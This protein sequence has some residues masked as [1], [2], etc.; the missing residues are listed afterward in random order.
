MKPEMKKSIK[1]AAIIAIVAVVAIIAL[2]AGMTLN[3]KGVTV[4]NIIHEDK[5]LV[6]KERLAQLD[7]RNTGTDI[8]VIQPY[9]THNAVFAIGTP[10]K[11]HNFNR[12]DATRILMQ[13][14]QDLDTVRVDTIYLAK[15]GNKVFYL[16]GKFFKSLGHRYKK[17]EDMNN[18]QILL[19]IPS[20][21]YTLNDSVA[22]QPHHGL[23]AS[24]QSAKDWNDMMNLL[25]PS[26][27]GNSI[28]SDVIDIAKHL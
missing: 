1:I 4:A 9:G 12:I 18:A 5:I 17:H 19:E 23:F 13:C 11:Q 25:I 16:E 20:N 22:Y 15:N 26:T 10:T 3:K 24:F 21:T 8:E 27:E 2:I 7:P 6:S 14:A 28:F